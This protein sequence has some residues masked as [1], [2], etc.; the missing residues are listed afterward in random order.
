VQRPF[1]PHL[2]T[3]TLDSR[4]MKLQPL[5]LATISGILLLSTAAQAQLKAPRDGTL[6]NVTPRMAA[7][8]TA[9]ATAPAPA[10]TAS[11]KAT[12]SI[13][14]QTVF[15]ADGQRAALGWLMLLDRKDWGSSWSA[16]S[17]F[18]RSQVPLATW[19]EGIPKTRD[20]MGSFVEREPA[21]AAYR[22]TMPGRP[23]GDY[24][25]VV[26]VSKFTNEEQVEELVSTMREA[27]GSWRVI[28]YSTR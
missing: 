3:N 13:D 19:M 24:V 23:E 4:P 11:G 21:N 27:D 15:V 28:G 17:S 20:P 22:T 7:P 1:P 25:T 16:A 14:E 8:A 5:A 10:A 26:Y 9:P 18:F 12:P 6:G 2:Y